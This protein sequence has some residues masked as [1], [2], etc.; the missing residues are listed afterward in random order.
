MLGAEQSSVRNRLLA[1]LP[2]AEYRKLLPSLENVTLGFGD[3]LYESHAQIRHVYFP[4][5][6]FV[7]MLTTVSGGRAVE[8]GLIGAEGM[9]GVP[10]ALGVAVS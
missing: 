10:M 1:A 6:C 5:D 2:R 9:V 4:N 3:I 7:S 8:V